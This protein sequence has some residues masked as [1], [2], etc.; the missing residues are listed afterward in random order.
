MV[1]YLYTVFSIHSPTSTAIGSNT[2][3]IMGLPE[4]EDR[5]TLKEIRDLEA[6]MLRSAQ[7]IDPT[8]NR[9]MMTGWYW[10]RS[11]EGFAP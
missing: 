2:A 3:T 6:E 4:R 8:V 5:L 1:R 10:L 7:E 9:V 11:D